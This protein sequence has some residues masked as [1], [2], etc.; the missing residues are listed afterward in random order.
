MFKKVISFF[1]AIKRLLMS[2]ANICICQDSWDTK[3]CFAFSAVRETKHMGI[4]LCIFL[5]LLI[6]KKEARSC[7]TFLQLLSQNTESSNNF[8]PICCEHLS[9]LWSLYQTLQRKW[10]EGAFTEENRGLDVGCKLSKAWLAIARTSAL[11]LDG[12]L[13]EVC[14]L[15]MACYDFYF[16]RI[17]LMLP[18]EWSELQTM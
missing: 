7:P 12:R 8:S 10:Q 16:H 5:L 18:W 11:E 14:E 17:T 2:S 1:E 3:L 9:L 13:I 4:H 15:R 6:F